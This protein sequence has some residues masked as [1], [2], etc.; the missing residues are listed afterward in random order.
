VHPCGDG[1]VCIQH[2]VDRA[3]MVFEQI[4]ELLD[5]GRGVIGRNRDPAQVALVI[6]TAVFGNTLDGTQI[7]GR[8]LQYPAFDI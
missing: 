1:A 2:R 5:T 8:L 3:E 7:Q 4:S 6:G